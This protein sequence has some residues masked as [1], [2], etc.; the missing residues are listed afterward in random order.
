MPPPQPRAAPT[1][2]AAPKTTKPA[3]LAKSG[4]PLAKRQHIVDK[5]H[6]VEVPD[7]YRWLEHAAADDTQQWL[8]AQQQYA[9][10]QLDALPERAALARRLS[11]LSYIDSISPPYRRGNRFFVRKRHANKEKAIWYWRKGNAGAL[12]VLLDPNTMSKDGSVS[13]KGVTP[14]YDGRLVAYKLS[15]NN[16]DEAT[17]YLMEVAT[18]KVLKKDTIKGAKYASPSWDPKGDGFYYTRLPLDPSIP[19]ADRPGYAEIYYHKVGQDPK[20]DALVHARTGDPRTFIN[21]ELSRDGRYLF[22]YQYH[23]WRNNDVFYKDLTKHKEFRPFAVGLDAKF[24]VYA[25]KGQF[26]VHTNY[27]APRWRVMKASPREPAMAKWKELV[28]QHPAAVLRGMSVVGGQLAL[29]YLDK[30]S[31]RMSLYSLS[32]KLQRS[33]ALPGIGSLT[34][35]TGNPDDDTFY[36]GFS[37]Y[38]TPTTIY[39]SSVTKGGAKKYFEVNAPVDPAP[40]TVRQVWY[41][42]KDGTPISMFLVHRKDMVMNGKTPFILAGY[43]G[44]NLLEV[45]YFNARRFVWLEKGGAFALP[46]LRGGGEYGEQWHRAG[47][48]L[49]KQNVFDDFIAAARFLIA[50]G[51]TAPE[52]LAI[53]GGSNGGLLV[54]AAMVQR[55]NLFG[56]VICAVPLLDMVRY[57]LH[58]SG[59]TW[60]GEYGSADDEAQFKVLY[61]YSPYHHVTA[62]VSYPALLMLSADS[63]DRVDPL[64][65]RKFVAAVRY[66]TSSDNPV[67]LRIETNAGHGGGDMTKKVVARETDVYAFLMQ[68]FNMN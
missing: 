44:F 47:M 22:V 35:P 58:G 9:R 64:H 2:Q 68:R 42:S 60:I 8:A 17:L 38:T 41:K 21:A 67:L 29:R 19:T 16:A 65:A 56:A 55:P 53:R 57:H 54:G 34:G 4:P 52:R 49:N 43:G 51:Y 45:P 32:G 11:A 66:A 46:N 5:I 28:P 62:G 50:K 63:D 3:A 39:R 61:G 31:S 13:L 14:S 30:A 10:K 25:W 7:P 36:Y 59:K 40:Y 37:S 15:E 26:Y 23:G 27:Q 48:L 12:K 6:G 18:G 24:D 20:A 33:I 1:A